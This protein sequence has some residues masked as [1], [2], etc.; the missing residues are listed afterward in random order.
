MKYKIISIV[1]VVV[2]LIVSFSIQTIEPDRN[3]YHQHKEAAE[4]EACTDHDEAV[5][6]THLPLLNIVTDAK[7]PN[8]YVYKTDGT[9]LPSESGELV[10]NNEQVA[11]TI[12]YFDSETEN[13]HLTD[14]PV[15][16]E[17][18]M[19]RIRGASSRAYDKNGY[20]LNF[21]QENLIDR[22]KVSF[23]GMTADDDWVLH[24]PFLDKTLIRNYM[25]Y[26]LAG[27]FM[28][29]APNVRFCEAYLNGEYIGVYLIVE[30]ITYNKNGRINIEQTNPGMEE[31]S[32]IVEI[33]RKPM[34]ETVLIETFA[35]H[36]YLTFQ[37]GV[38]KGYFQ[39]VYPSKTLTEE[40]KTYIESYIS[41]FE[42]T[43]YSFTYNDREEGY[44]KYIDV[45]SFVDYFLMNEF[46][47]NYDAMGFSTFA[48]K[49]IGGKMKL[50]V[51][52]F[53]SAFD[54]YETSVIT[55][56]TFLMQNMMWY[57]YLFKD[58]EFV[59]KVEKRYYDLRERLF[60]EEYLYTYIDETIEYLGPAIERNF[61][62]WGY[63]FN[64]EY[65]G[66]SYD[67]LQPA[68]RNVR[69]YEESIK[70][71]KDCI[72]LRI[73][74]MDANLDRLYMLCHESMNKKYIYDKEAN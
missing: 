64:S 37:F 9:N 73:E 6:C 55:P 57:K 49:D 2:T 21:K 5:F 46:T 25:C 13:N 10:H 52:D 50:C 60:N 63:S 68:E 59:K 23:D 14:E 45:D 33:D 40:Q 32:F 67:Y 62:K 22:K 58:E 4:K 38:N 54:Y 69:S 7:M 16:E 70:Q 31:T 19:M 39:V 65:N 26:N 30:E 51:W 1:L 41:K 74:H 27:E 72:A 48:Y 53:N 17:R 71:L 3:R 66:K 36:S 43:L 44:I 61:E 34:D 18:A 35:S 11:A 20:L 12:Q 24:G 29:Y 28:E 47:L 15:W 8:P 42:K 56:E